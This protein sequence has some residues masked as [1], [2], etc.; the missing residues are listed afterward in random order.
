M[1]PKSLSRAHA[2]LLKDA[3]RRQRAVFASSITLWEM[4]MLVTHGRLRLDRPIEEALKRLIDHPLIEI[5]PITIAIA[6]QAAQYSLPD[7]ADQLIVA[8]ARCHALKLVTAD[9]RIRDS[10]YIAVL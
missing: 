8:T 7:P 6:S 4:A 1:E 2:R 10:G 9:Q 3:E 5:L